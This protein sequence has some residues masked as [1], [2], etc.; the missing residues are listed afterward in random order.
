MRQI[1]EGTERVVSMRHGGYQHRK[2]GVV[3]LEG[4]E[5]AVLVVASPGTHHRHNVQSVVG[6]VGQK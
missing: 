4:L 1:Q 5:E 6:S 3:E 2:K